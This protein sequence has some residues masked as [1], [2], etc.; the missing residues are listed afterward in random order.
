VRR[1]SRLNRTHG[2]AERRLQALPVL[3]DN[4][5][6]RLAPL[7]V[8]DWLLWQ[9]GHQRGQL[10]S[11]RLAAVLGDHQQL[12]MLDLRAVLFTVQFD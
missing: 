5:N 3:V 10:F 1:R 12:G 6:R 2:C 11:S 8:A 9:E 4:P 7:S